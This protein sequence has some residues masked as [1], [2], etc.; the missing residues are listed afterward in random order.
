MTRY[1]GVLAP[2]SRWRPL[3]VPKP[4]AE[5]PR[6]R[7]HVDAVRPGR[8]AWTPR[9]PVAPDARQ[10][11]AGPVAPPPVPPPAVPPELLLRVPS[12]EPEDEPYSRVIRIAHWRRLMD[13]RLLARAPRIDWSSL[14]ARTFGVDALAG[15]TCRGRLSVLE[16]VSDPAKANAFLEEL[17]IAEVCPASAGTR[18]QSA[19]R[20]APEQPRAP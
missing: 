3:V 12:A 5:E 14:L 1:H 8:D 15:P 2:A 19:R 20:G 18:D 7:G 9:A 10:T 4:R 13:G 16:V 11:G 6:C 17:A